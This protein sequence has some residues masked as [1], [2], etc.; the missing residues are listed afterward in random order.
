[1]KELQK[2]HLKNEDLALEFSRR[3]LDEGVYIQ[4]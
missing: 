1:M 2:K 3:L 4:L